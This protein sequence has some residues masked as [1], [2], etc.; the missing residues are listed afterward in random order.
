MKGAG[1]EDDPW[2]RVDLAT[3][4]KISVVVAEMRRAIAKKTE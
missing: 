3:G 1:A 4:N 2:N